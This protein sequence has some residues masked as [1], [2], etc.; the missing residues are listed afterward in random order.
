MTRS[1]T[2]AVR[3]SGA[4]DARARYGHPDPLPL[5]AQSGE[6]ARKTPAL[7]T[8]TPTRSLYRRSPAKRRAGRPPP[9]AHTQ[10]SLKP[11]LP[12]IPDHYLITGGLPTP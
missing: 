12:K 3:R 2:G 7:A 9:A 6:A 8:D 11:D 10:T 1:L 5:P 4:Q